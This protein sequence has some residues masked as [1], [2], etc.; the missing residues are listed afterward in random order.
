MNQ[1]LKDFLFELLLSSLLFLPS[2]NVH[3][4]TCLQLQTGATANVRADGAFLAGACTPSLG[5]GYVAA[6]VLANTEYAGLLNVINN[7]LSGMTSAQVNSILTIG[8][9]LAALNTSTNLVATNLNNYIAA[10]NASITSLQNQVN[11]L[12]P[13]ANVFDPAVGAAFWSFAM[14][15]VI[16]CYLVARNAGVIINAIRRL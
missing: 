7:G 4:G 6:N 14:S 2:I 1:Q 16:G 11:L 8:S 12:N 5:A 15:F 13:S 3:A 10:N 9:S